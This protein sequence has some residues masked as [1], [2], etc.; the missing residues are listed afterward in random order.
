MTNKEFSVLFAACGIIVVLG[1]A[2]LI[3]QEWKRQSQTP[4]RVTI[5]LITSPS[6]SAVDDAPPFSVVDFEDM[7]GIDAATQELMDQRY[8]EGDIDRRLRSIEA[9]IDALNTRVFGR[10]VTLPGKGVDGI[11]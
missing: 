5:P 11:R 2:I 7:A 1:V 8:G 10:G 6:P 9:N 4:S 3:Q